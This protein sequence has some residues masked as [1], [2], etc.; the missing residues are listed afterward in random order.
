MPIALALM[1]YN[2]GVNSGPGRGARWLQLALNQQGAGVDVDGEVGPQ[3][4]DGC[5]RVDVGRAVND[6]AATQEAF[7]RS[8][9]TFPTFGK[10]WMNRLTD[11]KGKAAALSS[12]PVVVVADSSSGPIVPGPQPADPR[13]DSIFDLF[14]RILKETNMATIPAATTTTTTSDS[15]QRAADIA[16]MLAQLAKLLAGQKVVADGTSTQTTELPLTTIDKLLGGDVLA[17]KKT[18][19]AVIGYG[20]V[21]MLQIFGQ[22]GPALGASATPTGQVL[23]LLL[24][25]LGGAG[26]ASKADRVTQL[27]AL[28]TAKK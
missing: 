20:I 2:A 28:L 9:S 25:L 8:L 21:G 5:A 4:L 14:T 11:V 12:E 26:V 6:F 16:A 18:L 13:L 3:T 15:T 10:G 22:V 1:T 23:T 7:L 24:A 17:G 27:L 19:I